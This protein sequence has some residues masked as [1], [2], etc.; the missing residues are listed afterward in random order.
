MRSVTRRQCLCCAQLF[1][2]D[3][4]N[5]RHQKYCSETACRQA[6]KT[7]SANKW[8]G[9]PENAGYHSGSEAVRRVQSWQ[10]AHP[11]YREQQKVK[12]RTA[13]QDH[14]QDLC[15]NGTDVQVPQ[16][17]QQIPTAQPGT[18]QTQLPS[19]S[20]LQ[21]FIN[22]QPLVSVGLISHLFNITLQDD[23]ASTTRFLQKLGEDITNGRRCDVF[24]K[25]SNLPRAPA[26]GAAA[27]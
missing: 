16:L 25:T 20:A 14:C 5:A 21:D 7:A 26:P 11:E 1:D 8:L 6:S 24:T 2:A 17:A 22:A 3:S 19:E 13:L 27:L 18:G 10:K 15:A 12:R 23:I 9:K 4:R